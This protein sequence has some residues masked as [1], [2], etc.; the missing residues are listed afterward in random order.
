[1]SHVYVVDNIDPTATVM[2]RDNTPARVL[3]SRP[4]RIIFLNRN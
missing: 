1:M 4:T 3:Q 2:V